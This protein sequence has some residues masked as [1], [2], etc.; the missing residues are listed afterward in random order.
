M[1]KNKIFE[2]YDGMNEEE[3]RA[4]AKAFEADLTSTIASDNREFII[5]RLAIVYALRKYKF[6]ED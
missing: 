1:I 2:V 6:K 5:G 3:L 4:I